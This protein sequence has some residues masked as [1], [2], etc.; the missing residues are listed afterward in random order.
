MN[1]GQRIPRPQ[2]LTFLALSLRKQENNKE[3]D[4]LSEQSIHKLKEHVLQQWILNDFQL[5]N[6]RLSID[7]LSKLLQISSATIIRTMQRVSGIMLGITEDQDPAVLARAIQNMALKFSLDGHLSAQRQ[8]A[9]LA[10]AQGD[11]YVPYLSSALNQAIGNV[12][13]SAKNMG[14]L[15]GS[16]QPPGKV[17]NNHLHLNPLSPEEPQKGNLLSVAKAIGIIEENGLNR[18]LGDQ[19]IKAQLY[20]ENGIKDT[21]DITANGT[22]VDSDGGFLTKKLTHEERRNQDYEDLDEIQ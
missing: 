12:L 16:V 10:D 17:L 22:Q 2:G 14:T 21:P 7:Q 9:I 5:N 19:D 4:Q 18:T 8:V 6:K 3:S 20:L 11:R 1:K 15:A 13:A